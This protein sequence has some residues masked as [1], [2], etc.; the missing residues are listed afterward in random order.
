[1]HPPRWPA[2]LRLPPHPFALYFN[3]LQP[4][5]DR[6][7]LATAKNRP[8]KQ[9]NYPNFDKMSANRRFFFLFVNQ[10]PLFPC[11]MLLFLAFPCQNVTCFARCAACD[12]FQVFQVRGCRPV[13]LCCASFPGGSLP[14]WLQFPD[15][16]K[17]VRYFCKKFVIILQCTKKVLY[18]HRVKKERKGNTPT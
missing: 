15:P 16:Q 4:R 6:K 7:G 3:K 18:L 11:K 12:A 8:Q 13:R 14:W 10:S 2:V 17:K 1:M 5:N 9:R